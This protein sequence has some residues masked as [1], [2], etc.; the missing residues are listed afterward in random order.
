[1]LVYHVIMLWC[2]GGFVPYFLS[3]CENE[4]LVVNAFDFVLPFCKVYSRMS[5]TGLQLKAGPSTRTQRPI[6]TGASVLAIKYA[7]GVMMI[8]DTLGSYGNLSRFTDLKR[9]V[10]VGDNALLG[11]GGEY[12]DFQYIQQLLNDRTVADFCEADGMNHTLIPSFFYF[13]SCSPVFAMM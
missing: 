3:K 4:N 8:S 13:A 9:I 1:M 12:S 6:V 7:G 10:E 5:G 11:A 2:S